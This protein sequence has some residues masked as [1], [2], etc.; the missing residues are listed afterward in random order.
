MA[1]MEGRGGL[2]MLMLLLMPSLLRIPT[3]SRTRTGI[4]WWIL[5]WIL[6]VLPWILWK[7]NKRSANK[8]QRQ[9]QSRNRGE[10]VSFD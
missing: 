6:S 5:W 10:D 2:Q 9:D 7:I 8:I 1:T 3:Y 4:L